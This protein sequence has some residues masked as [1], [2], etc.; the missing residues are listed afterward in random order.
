ML[1]FGKGSVDI[2]AVVRALKDIRYDGL[3]NFE[4]PGENQC[5]LPVR[6]YK[7]QY[8]KSMAE[9]LDKEAN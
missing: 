1:P 4:I 2:L 7:L 3:F 5:P 9:Y 8:A 6:A